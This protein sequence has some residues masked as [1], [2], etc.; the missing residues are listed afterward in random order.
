ML[1]IIFS[2]YWI[3]AL[4]VGVVT[5]IP[6]VRNYRLE[7]V[8][9]IKKILNIQLVFWLI[10]L[11]NF[12]T[13]LNWGRKFPYHELT[14]IAGMLGVCFLI[15]VIPRAINSWDKLRLLKS[16]DLFFGVSGS[17][18]LLH[19]LITGG[20]YFA[21]DYAK[22]LM[23]FDGHRVLPAFLSFILLALSHSYFVISV[24]SMKKARMC[25]KKPD[26]ISG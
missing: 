16:A 17:A 8:P 10:I 25:L 22:G 2:I 18:L 7:T 26:I 4:V 20:I 5:A 11:N 14:R 9:F 24:L 1:D 3:T 23:Y 21:T 19:Y 6:A 12:V 13:D 15:I